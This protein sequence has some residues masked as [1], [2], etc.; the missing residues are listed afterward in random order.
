MKF[1]KTTSKILGWK[2]TS[3]FLKAVLRSP[4]VALLMLERKLIQIPAISLLSR[5][6]GWGGWVAG[7]IEIKAKSSRLG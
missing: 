7:G 6:G 4:W 1:W 3:N 5:V 2:T